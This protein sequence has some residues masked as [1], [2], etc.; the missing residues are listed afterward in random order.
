MKVA[1]RFLR[2]I[3]GSFLLALVFS[4]TADAAEILLVQSMKAE[5]RE[6]FIRYSGPGMAASLGVGRISAVNLEDPCCA[7]SSMRHI[8]R[9]VGRLEGGVRI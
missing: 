1:E 6:A 5:Q 8:E 7:C 4:A 3:A 9:V 2:L